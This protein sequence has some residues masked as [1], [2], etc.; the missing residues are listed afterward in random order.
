MGVQLQDVLDIK[1]LR[2]VSDGDPAVENELITLYLATAEDCLQKMAA[3]AGTEN[4]AAWSEAVHT[5][6]G[7]SA[8]MYMAKM[9]ALCVPAERGA[10]TVE[11][12]L[13]ACREVRAAYEG[14]LPA[15]SAALQRK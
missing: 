10:D 9:V 8:S 13:A 12:R 5:L 7:A 1:A 15:L 11:K 4:L 2:E 3:L 14:M 6:K